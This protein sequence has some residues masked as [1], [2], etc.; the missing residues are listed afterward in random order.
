M[1]LG[2]IVSRILKVGENTLRSEKK[3]NVVSKKK[4]K[5]G[6]ERVVFPSSLC[7]LAAFENGT[8]KGII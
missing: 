1:E 4:K 5:K 7:Y 6:K 2:I 3:D 8:F